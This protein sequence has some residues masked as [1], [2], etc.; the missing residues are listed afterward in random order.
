M[1]ILQNIFSKNLNTQILKG[2]LMQTTDMTL[3]Q[4]TR[5]RF[6]DVIPSTQTDL[7]RKRG[8]GYHNLRELDIIINQTFDR[9]VDDVNFSSIITRK[10]EVMEAL[11]RIKLIYHDKIV[12]Y[13]LPAIN[14]ENLHIKEFRT[15]IDPRLSTE[16]FY[17]RVK[18]LE[19]SLSKRKITAI[20]DELRYAF[21]NKIKRD[22]RKDRFKVEK[23][24]KEEAREKYQRARQ[25]AKPPVQQ[26]PESM[27]SLRISLY[28][29]SLDYIKATPEISLCIRNPES[30]ELM[31]QLKLLIG[32]DEDTSRKL[33]EIFSNS[34]NVFYKTFIS[35]IK[36]T[37]KTKNIILENILKREAIKSGK[38]HS[39]FQMI[40]M[41]PTTWNWLSSYYNSNTQIKNFVMKYKED[42]AKSL[43]D[44]I[45]ETYVKILRSKETWN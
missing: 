41:N 16:E 21:L 44:L 15:I 23:A 40:D 7:S 42:Y 27:E 1:Y 30:C 2:Y 31:P 29:T 9:L 8:E 36:D 18:E 37:M 35:K 33:S 3:E 10:P 11:E 43:A 39:K 13:D 17:S 20:P 28:Q 12:S 34:Q 26:S 24:L 4:R 22:I 6:A 14:F 25:F 45:D 19:I 38:Q 32:K 5:K